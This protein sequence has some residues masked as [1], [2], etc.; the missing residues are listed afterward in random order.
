MGFYTGTIVGGGSAGLQTKIEDCLALES[1]YWEFVEE[2]TVSTKTYRVWK[3]KG[4]AWAG[5]AEFFF[6]FTQNNATTLIIRPFEEWNASTKKCTGLTSSAS[7][8]TLT[9]DSL[10]RLPEA[11]PTQTSTGSVYLSSI[12]SSATYTYYIGIGPQGIYVAISTSTDTFYMGLYEPSGIYASGEFPLVVLTFMNPTSHRFSRIPGLTGSQNYS[13]L[14][15][16]IAHDSIGAIPTGLA[17]FANKSVLSRRRVSDYYNILRG[18]C[19]AWMLVSATP[20]AGVV[21][22]DTITIGGVTH[23]LVGGAS[24][25]HH[26]IASNA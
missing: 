15:A 2:C 14:I 6:F 1:A 26:W 20:A 17:Q 16:N 18:Q 12:P 22:G 11:D 24:Y 13:M 3:N 10:G 23:T 7:T 4:H 8:G 5:N 19:P 9:L 21:Q 25:G